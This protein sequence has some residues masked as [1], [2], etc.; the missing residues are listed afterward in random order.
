[1]SHDPIALIGLSCR[2]PK[3]SDPTEF[4]RLLQDGIDAITDIPEERVNLSGAGPSAST[5]QGG[6]LDRVDGFDPGFFGISPRE[7]AAMDPQQRLTLELA[8]EALEDARLIPER[9]RG[10]KAGVFVGAI[11]DDYA[12]LQRR[13][14]VHAITQHTMTGLRRG[15]IAN[16]VSYVLGLQGPSVTI[17]AAQASSL[18][19]VH[20]A[21]ESLRRGESELAIAGGV[22]LNLAW[23]STVEAERFGGLSPDGR[24][25][26]FDA[27]AGGYVR[28]EGGGLVV[29]KRLQDA[30]A[31]GDRIHAVIRGSAVNNDGGGRSLTAPRQAAQE[32]VLRTAYRL[33]GVEPADVQ[34]VEL[35]GTGTRVGDPIEAAA[36]GAVLGTARGRTE[37]LRVGSAKTN[38]GHLEGASGIAGLIKTVLSL[39]SGELPASLNFDTANPQIPMDALGLRVQST[40][41]PW[42]ATDQPRTAGVSSFGMGGTNCHLVLTQAPAL[43][44][45][46]GR[47]TRRPACW[48]LSGRDEKA[49]Q[50]QA[51]SLRSHLHARPDLDVADVGYSLAK[52]RTSF[53]HRAVIVGD[54]RNALLQGLDAVVDGEPRPDVLRG[55]AG[56]DGGKTVFVF[57]GQGSQW[58]GMAAQ[59]MDS[60]PVFAERMGQCANALAPHTDWSLFRALQDSALWE[61]VDVVQPALFA[62]MVSLAELWR[63]YGIQPD[64]VVGHS[65]GEIAAACVAGALTLQD[66]CRV[67]AVRSRAL[68]AIAGQGGMASIAVPADEVALDDGLSLAAVNGPRSVVVSGEARRLDEWLARHR[69]QGIRVGRINVDYA[70]HS[71][72]VEAV[73]ER[74]LAELADVAPRPAEIPM[75]S[76]VTGRWASGSDLD[77]WYWYCN[78]RETVGFEPAIRT[79]V[80]SDHGV[81]VEASPH[82]VLTAA[83]QE[84]AESCARDAVVVGSLRRDDGGLDRFL[85]SLGE[86]YARGIQPDWEAVF[87]GTGARKVDLPTYAF[88]RSGYWLGAASA[89]GTHEG[90]QGP[91]EQVAP[92]ASGGAPPSEQPQ[93]PDV[94]ADPSDS[95]DLVR[96]H[97]A[98]VLGHPSLDAVDPELAFRD[99][100]LDSHL[101]VELRNRLSTA[102]GL[103]L[104]T[105]LLFDYPTCRAVAGYL[106][107]GAS[108]GAAHGAEHEAGPNAGEPIALVGM[109]CRL[110]G[111]VESPEA[112]WRLVASGGDAIGTFPEDRGWDLAHLYDPDPDQRGR[113]YVRAGG[114]LERATEFDAGFFGISP[115]EAAAMD[116]QQRL[117][118]E[119][120]W[121]T[122]ERAAIDPGSLHGS[123]TGVFVGAMAPEYGPRLHEA[124]SDGYTLTGNLPAVAAGRLSYTFGLTGAAVTVDTACSSSLVA[125]H[126]AVPGAAS[127]RVRPG[128]GR[129]GH[130]D[131]HPG[132]VRGVLPPARA[133]P[134]RPV[135]A[136]RRGR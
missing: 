64:A 41:S 6:F 56:A 117:L 129:R 20:M 18:V 67:V 108:G 30:L 119:T 120:A 94:P 113:S 116:P 8:W 12:T 97:A 112:L 53:A 57:P 38:I 109:S 118:L 70:S 43:D 3:S 13:H 77:A 103:R 26:V 69:D 21:C 16:R 81:F 136:L 63:S 130:R 85:T 75:L 39:R 121:E 72:E 50:G 126:L 65:Q 84:T 19:A 36:L 90:D 79:L 55:I 82:P 24:C 45:P 127:G 91:A 46:G 135:Q 58:L 104:P 22:Q 52:T 83:V 23:E 28:G 133:G 107:A 122:F 42:T 87:H 71:P 92:V 68:A 99:L 80:E 44:E 101:S 100:G 132:H 93:T 123:R 11:A 35:H 59:L 60:S 27:R 125:L 10:G 89:P 61:R 48:V 110:P 73:R 4:W 88:Q 78:L 62:V 15:I 124:A 25:F 96:K 74:L 86:V 37:P 1:M 105:T 32:E 17:D 111:G 49:L 114:F 102:T 2:F 131:G 40:R 98:A 76:T 134:E 34:Y 31:D 106:H 95:L 115:R 14:G 29:L 66:A 7:A 5:V 9:L 54:D 47:G 128:A 51:R 33:A